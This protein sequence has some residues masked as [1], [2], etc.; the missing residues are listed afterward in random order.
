MDKVSLAS[1][2]VVLQDQIRPLLLDD[3]CC[4]L[5]PFLVLAELDWIHL[6]MGKCDGFLFHDEI[7]FR[8]DLLETF[9]VGH[10]YVSLPASP[11]KKR[12]FQKDAWEDL[13]AQLMKPRFVFRSF[14]LPNLRS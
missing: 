3:H 1:H 13:L 2:L 8:M 9:C 5:P 7:F 11:R 4:V 10:E 14:V 12:I 6:R